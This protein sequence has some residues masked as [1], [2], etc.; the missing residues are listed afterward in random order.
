M[1]D[2]AKYRDKEEVS[3]VRKEC[4][5]IDNLRDILLK[6]KTIDEITLKDMDREIKAIITDS[7]EFAQASEEPDPSEL[8]TNILVEA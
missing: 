5:P 4:D 3:R 8:Y 1:S 7:A 2:P 6:T